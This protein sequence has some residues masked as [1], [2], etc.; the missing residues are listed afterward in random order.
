M[1][2]LGSLDAL[3]RGRIP[4]L[5]ALA[6]SN[7]AGKTTFYET[8]LEPR[9][10]SFVNADRIAATLLPH[11]PDAVSLQAAEAARLLRNDLVGR[12]QT[13]IMETVFSD[14]KGAKLAELRDAQRHGFAV[15]LVFVGIVSSELSEARVQG[16]VGH[17]GH[18]V[19]RELIHDR[20]P[21]TLENLGR[22]LAFVDLALLFD[23]SDADEPYRWVATWEGGRPVQEA[24]VLPAWYPHSARGFGS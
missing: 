21:R 9:G 19:R 6:G 20:F 7:G 24:A 15:V 18:D 23:N 22:A 12:K 1:P 11:S 3:L 4:V 5:V 2:D 10:L 8:F 13:F 16:R 14:R 17:G